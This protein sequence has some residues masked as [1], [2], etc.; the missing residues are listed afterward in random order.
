MA[1]AMNDA[2]LAVLDAMPDAALV[3][4]PDGVILAANAQCEAVL[5]YRPDELVDTSVD[6]LVPEELRA[7][8]AGHRAHFTVEPHVRMSGVNLELRAI[9]RKGHTIPVEILLAP[10]LDAAG[11]QGMAIAVI[12]DISDR[13]RAEAERLLL[14]E[15]L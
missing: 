14:E 4:A 13:K 3:V 5:G 10:L 7:P 1:A 2:F 15:E 11:T 6:L 8:H 12:R 9:H